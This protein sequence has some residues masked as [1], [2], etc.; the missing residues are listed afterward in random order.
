[1]KISRT[2]SINGTIHLPGDKSISH[3][4]AMI[5]AMAVGETRIENFATSVDCASTLDCIAALGVKVGRDGNNVTVTGVGKSG[6]HAPTEPLD[7]GNSGTTMRLM[8]GVLAVRIL[9]LR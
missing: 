8:S 1:M 7:C 6:F 4:S 3:R 9:I 5:A 2:S